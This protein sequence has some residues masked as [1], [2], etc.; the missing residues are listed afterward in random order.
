MNFIE[1]EVAAVAD[2]SVTIS[3][4]AFVGGSLRV[5][6]AAKRPVAAG[7]PMVVGLRPES[8]AI[9]AA[10]PILNLVSDFS[11]NLGGH[12]QV[13][14]TAPGPPSLA[15]V[16]NQRLAIGRGDA[17]KVGLASGRIYIFDEGP[18]ALSDKLRG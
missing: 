4:P 18:R 6:R 9:G 17:L 12:T 8:L 14:A 1:A 3:H 16:A 7:E 2:G 10:Q 11:E 15:I 5:E 13:Y